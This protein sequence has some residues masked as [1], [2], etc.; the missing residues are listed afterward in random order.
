MGTETAPG[1]LPRTAFA[2]AVLVSVVVLFM[3]AAGVP[4]APP[5]TDKLVHLALFAALAA[6]GRWSGIP[7]V[8]LAVGLL[9]YAAA[10][11]VI[12]GVTPLARSASATGGLADAAGIALGFLGRA[13]ATRRTR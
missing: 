10:S 1:V 3:P 12:Q 4:T 8:P 2:L 6:T 7:A 5:G 9:G 11:E 13:W